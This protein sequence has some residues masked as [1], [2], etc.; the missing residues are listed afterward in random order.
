ME[1]PAIAW[2]I[3]LL[4]QI[5]ASGAAAL[6]ASQ[7]VCD[8]DD[9]LGGIVM[10]FIF[11]M[12]VGPLFNTIVFMMWL[13]GS[14]ETYNAVF[15]EAGMLN[16]LVGGFTVGMS[17]IFLSSGVFAII[18][19]VVWKAIG[20]MIMAGLSIVVGGGSSSGQSN[21]GNGESRLDRFVK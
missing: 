13:N 19:A 4:T 5:G 3:E 16:V 9:F 12:F 6:A 17:S 2:H 15:G 1:D 8:E 7:I 21:T 11:A 18:G 10:G 14:P 20:P